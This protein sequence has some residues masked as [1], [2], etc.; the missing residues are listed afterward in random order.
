MGVDPNAELEH[1]DITYAPIETSSLLF[2][3]PLFEPETET[4]S[5][6]S[7]V[8]KAAAYDDIQSMLSTIRPVPQVLI[9]S[10]AFSKLL[11]GYAHR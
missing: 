1:F 8:H 11:P 6:V 10:H 2:R 4:D 5:L 9:L 7:D 3:N